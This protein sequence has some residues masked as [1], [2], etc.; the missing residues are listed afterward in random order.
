MDCEGALKVIP[1]NIENL[2]LRGTSLKNTESIYGI[3]VFTGHDTKIM[4]NQ[5]SSKYKRSNIERIMNKQI[6][7]IILL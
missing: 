5:A 6:Y 7:W 2:L 4:N 3:V 1:L